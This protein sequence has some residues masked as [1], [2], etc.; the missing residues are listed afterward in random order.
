ML[1]L[2]LIAGTCSA[3]QPL[4]PGSTQGIDETNL[5]TLKN[6]VAPVVRTAEDLGEVDPGLPL[7]HMLL[8][9]KR[10]AEKEA[11]VKSAIDDLHNPKSP[12][13]HKWLTA[14]QFGALY[15]A[16]D[17]EIAEVSDWL[18]SHGLNVETVNPGRTV[19]QFS[20]TASQVEE[21]FHTQIHN[22]N[23]KG[24][25]H[26]SNITEPS[27]PA[28][29]ADLVAGVP[30]SNF[31]PHPL[32]SGLRTFQRDAGTAKLVQ[33]GTSSTPTF[34]GTDSNGNTYELVAP[35]DFAQIYNL[36]PAWKAGTRGAGQTVV[37]AED[38]QIR[39]GDV[40]TFRNAFGLSGYAGT[41][42]QITPTGTHPCLPSGLNANED[43]AALDAEWAGATAPDANIVLASCADTTTQFGGLLAIMN[44]ISQP[45]PPPIISLSYGLCE[46]AMG[47][48]ET[49]QFYYTYQQAAAEGVSVFVSSGDAGSAVCD[50]DSPYASY[51]IAVNGF[52][53]TPYNVAV[54]GT[55]FYD[56]LQGTNKNYWSATNGP[57]FTSALSY[58]PEK[59]W[60]DSCADSDLLA[61]KQF[62]T[63]YGSN[64]LCNSPSGSSYID[65]IAG[66]GGQSVDFF[67]PNWQSVYGNPSD[68]FRDV[69]DVSLFAANGFYGHALV[70]CFSDVIEGGAPCSYSAPNTLVFQAAGGTS[71]A[72]PA[73][74]GIFALITQKYGPQG[75]PDAGL[76]SLASQEYGT[77]SKPNSTNLTACNST[78]GNTVGGSCTFNDV[79]HGGIGVP[80]LGS[81]TC[82]GSSLSSSGKSIYGATSTSN[83]SFNSAYE[84]GQG[85]D[86]ATG[87]GSVNATNL[88]NGWSAVAAPP[89]S[90]PPAGASAGTVSVSLSASASTVAQ[91]A[92]ITLTAKLSQN[93]STILPTG[94]VIFQVNGIAFGTATVSGTTATFS[95]STLPAGTDVITAEYA[96]DSNYAASS[97]SP[98]VTV[99]VIN[100]TPDFTLSAVSSNLTLTQGQ[101]GTV[102]LE[103]S[104][105][106]TFNGAVSLACSGAPSASTC[107]VAPNSVTLGS[108]QSKTVTVTIATTASKT[109]ATSKMPG[110]MGVTGG[111]SLAGAMLLLLPGRRRRFSNLWTTILLFGFGMG[112]IATLSGCGSNTANSTIP[113]TALGASTLTIT[114]T[115][116]GVTH[117]VAISV[118]VK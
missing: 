72:A 76:Y 85:W 48:I 109:A 71:F 83:L 40:A 15:G 46:P 96:G 117:T 84:T 103:L 63:A 9:L 86:F 107:N 81:N 28:A 54:G 51:G 59:T 10:P 27:I 14:A 106:D 70:F 35:G 20:G 22:L 98:S 105:N 16:S 34:T 82:F 2:S 60:N 69:P 3:Q 1:A 56:T 114:G 74:A 111:A 39:S 78:N 17:A 66:S 77:Q 73:M 100:V 37:V 36:N 90:V 6:T 30:L 44:L 52:S 58:I 21:A 95:T 31:M 7:D 87:L 91:S 45:A 32:Y 62:P 88:V 41:F 23:I 108:T 80:C 43:E 92:A 79:T 118:T 57:T 24:E 33:I 29:F 110:W 99:T 25:H 47:S 13:Y 113:G 42:A 38:S 101:T 112:A 49:S 64:G 50:Q 104:G 97:P 68:G 116:A 67:K 94:S 19:I 11:A 53:T 8:Q 12:N 115:S 102:S 4:A 89:T 61:N 65:T 5:I 26:F 93:I 55:D 75:N 18:R